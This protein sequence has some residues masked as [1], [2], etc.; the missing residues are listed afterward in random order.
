VPLF[1]AMVETYYYGSPQSVPSFGPIGQPPYTP[2]PFGGGQS[3]QP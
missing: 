3:P 2:T 1:R